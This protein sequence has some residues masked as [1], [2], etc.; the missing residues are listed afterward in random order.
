[1][2]VQAVLGLLAYTD[3]TRSPTAVAALLGP[4]HRA[5]VADAV[6]TAVLQHLRLPRCSSL[7]TL[8]KH[9]LVTQQLIRSEM[10]TVAL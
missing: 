2:A 6:N 4:E 9:A 7:E 3:V 8:L 1:L 10:S 5:A